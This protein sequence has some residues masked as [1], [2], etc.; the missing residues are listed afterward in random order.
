MGRKSKIDLLPEAARAALVPWLSDPAW[1][2]QD[3]TDALNDLLDEIG[4]PADDR[5]AVDSVNRYAQRYQAQL[6]RM[7][8]RT[9]VAEAWV[10]QFGRVPEGRLGQM[11]IQLV[12]GL[13]WELGLRLSEDAPSVE[14]EDMP[15]AVRM[16]RDLSV[17][18]ERTERAS[19]I[20]VQREQEI[21]AEAARETAA[22]IDALAQQ[23][24]KRGGTLDPATLKRIREEIYGIVDQPR[25]V[26]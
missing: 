24:A 18:L 26:A 25:E 3:V 5:P 1:T 20:S 11:V 7:R 17:T 19:Q 4:H 16:L 15:A 22:K 9:Q 13:S 8:E 14:A 23:D 10:A 12:H 6:T 21:R 2:R